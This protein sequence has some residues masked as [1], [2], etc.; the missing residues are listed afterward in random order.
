MHQHYVLGYSHDR[1]DI[2]CTFSAMRQCDAIF[3]AGTTHAEECREGCRDAHLHDY[4]F[5]RSEA[6]RIGRSTTLSC[7][8]SFDEAYAS[9]YDY[10][11]G[12]RYAFTPYVKASACCD[13][14]TT[15]RKGFSHTRYLD[16]VP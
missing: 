11:Y 9:R 10:W 15:L 4:S 16:T 7:P 6:Y 3:G 1:P 12:N 13:Q 5:G 8:P 2:R 14:T